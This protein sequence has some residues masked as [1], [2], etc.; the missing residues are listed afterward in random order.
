[1]MTD[2]KL[3]ALTKAM[4]NMQSDINQRFDRLEADISEVKASAIATN[5]T[6]ESDIVP[7][8]KALSEGCDI[9]TGK[10]NTLQTLAESTQSDLD[11]VRAG[12]SVNSGQII[13]LQAI[14]D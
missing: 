11:I 2:Q 9:T 12:V 7:A 1:M 14:P 5:L 3:D 10:L 6:I 8:L 4:S 13:K